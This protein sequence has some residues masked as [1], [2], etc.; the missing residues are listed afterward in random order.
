MSES[1]S[2][3]DRSE[4]DGFTKAINKSPIF[5]LLGQKYLSLESGID[6]FL[7]GILDK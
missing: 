4:F 1:H 5:L 6:P 2:S 3:T 7:S